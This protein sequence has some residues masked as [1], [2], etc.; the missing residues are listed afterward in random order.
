MAKKK[1]PKQETTRP[2]EELDVVAVLHDPTT[3]GFANIPGIIDDDQWIEVG[4]KLIK[5]EG[6][7]VY[8]T[9]MLASLRNSMSNIICTPK[10]DA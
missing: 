1:K 9:T 8:L 3:V 7:R 5:E 4:C 10:E 6:A 2:W